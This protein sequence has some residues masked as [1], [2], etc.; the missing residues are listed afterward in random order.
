MKPAVG[1]SLPRSGFGLATAQAALAGA[2]AAKSLRQE[3]KHTLCSDE[4]LIMVKL[5]HKQESERVK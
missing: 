1:G 2:A 4:T 5:A 3:E